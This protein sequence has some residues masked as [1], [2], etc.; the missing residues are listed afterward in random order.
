MFNGGDKK[1]V[2]IA[3]TGGIGSGKTTAL[4]MFEARG[5]ACLNS[6]HVVHQLL[7][8]RDVRDRIAARLALEHVP[9]GEAGRQQLANVV[10]ADESKLR[11]L[12]EIIFPLVRKKL[13]EWME[14][15]EVRQAP[16]VV[17]EIPMLFESGMEDLFDVI[18]LVTAP[19]EV[20]QARNAGRLSQ[21]DFERRALQQMPEAEKRQ[22]S[23]FVFENTGSPDEM[24]EFI[25][26]TLATVTR[27]RGR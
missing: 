16:A 9:A 10:F 19:A 12:E 8:R 18:V 15:E 6:D 3:L 7:Q 20:R 1:P 11:G 22:R 27:S 5:A 26:R 4:A 23:D 13:T 17:V 14:S 24:D 21:A 25:D 2:R